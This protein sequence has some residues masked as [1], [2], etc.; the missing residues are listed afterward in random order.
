[1]SDNYEVVTING[2]QRPAHDVIEE[3]IIGRPLAEDEVVHH[4]NG[5]KRDNRPENLKVMKR[6]AHTSMHKR[7]E[8]FTP[9][10]LDKM[11]RSHSGVR[12]QQRKLTDEQ[13]TAIVQKLLRI[14]CE[15]Q[16]DRRDP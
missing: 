7:G 14:W 9:E 2:R 11:S 8:V 16:D 1:M 6:S 15:P 12:S 5:D 3:N 13:V 10:S 4:I